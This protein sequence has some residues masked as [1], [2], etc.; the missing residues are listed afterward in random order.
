MRRAAT[1]EQ[2]KLAAQIHMG[3]CSGPI[4]VMVKKLVSTEIGNTI[5]Q[6][7]MKPKFA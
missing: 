3:Y 4:G 5:D 6:L 1:N 7:P 2:V